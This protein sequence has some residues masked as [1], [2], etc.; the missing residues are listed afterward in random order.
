MMTGI[1]LEELANSS[2]GFSERINFICKLI[3]ELDNDIEK[4]RNNVQ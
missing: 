2:S 4:I 1:S 3:N